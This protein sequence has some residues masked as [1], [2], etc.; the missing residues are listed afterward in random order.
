MYELI[1]ALFAMLFL[2]LL[3]MY[4]NLRSRFRELSFRNRS[5]SSRFGKMAE[6]FMPLL[7]SYPYDKRNFRF[8]GNPIDGIQFEKDRIVLVEFKTSG[9]KLSATQKRI[10][11]LVSRGKVYFEEIRIR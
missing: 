10:R 9:S 6:Q 4:R 3:L 5:L 11:D 7:E 2:I 1:A 8:I